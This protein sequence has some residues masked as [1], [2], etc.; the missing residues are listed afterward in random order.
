MFKILYG[1]KTRTSFMSNNFL[2][3]KFYSYKH[4]ES[5]EN[6]ENVTHLSTHLAQVEIVRIVIT[7]TLAF[8]ANCTMLINIS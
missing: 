6:S 2:N 3:E 1:E 7:L 8:N 4:V 5:V